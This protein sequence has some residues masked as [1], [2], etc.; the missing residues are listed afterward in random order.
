MEGKKQPFKPG[1][2]L[3]SSYNIFQVMILYCR[4]TGKRMQNGAVMAEAGAINVSAKRA[5]AGNERDDRY[6]C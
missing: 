4:E 6:R 2:S 5:V 1:S 3:K